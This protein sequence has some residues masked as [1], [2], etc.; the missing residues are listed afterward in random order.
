MPVL[1]SF[2]ILSLLNSSCSESNNSSSKIPNGALVV[3]G[4]YVGMSPQELLT[5]L[6]DKYKDLVSIDPES[7]KRT[8]TAKKDTVLFENETA[9]RDSAR[10]WEKNIPASELPNSLPSTVV[11]E[12]ESMSFPVPDSVIYSYYLDWGD[13]ETSPNKWQPRLFRTLFAHCY[14]YSPIYL[15]HRHQLSAG[16]Y[17]FTFDET[18]KLVSIYFPKWLINDLFNVKDLSAEEFAKTFMNS[19]K[20]KEMKTMATEDGTNYWEYTNS[21]KGYKVMISEDK[22]LKIIAIPK[23]SERKFS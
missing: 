22:E 14:W 23:P 11:N 19:Y 7:H 4:F 8:F 9:R 13:I 6:K 10:I 3:K 18:D 15:T 5:L 17:F 12:I 2:S 21:Q 20:I 1:L 16:S